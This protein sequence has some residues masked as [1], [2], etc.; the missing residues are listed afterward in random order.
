MQMTLL[1]T[2]LVFVLRLLSLSS[3]AFS[4]GFVKSWFCSLYLTIIC[5][6]QIRQV[7]SLT[8][9]M[10]IIIWILKHQWMMP[11]EH[12]M[13][14]LLNWGLSRF[15]AIWG[16]QGQVAHLNW[17]E[18]WKLMYILTRTVCRGC[19]SSKYSCIYSPGQYAGAASQV[20]TLF[21]TYSLVN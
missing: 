14:H 9:R 15:G 5:S 2:F 7:S 10:T 4:V 20:C 13:T 6:L 21:E 1:S 17:T 12:F 19:Q 11:T 18:C 16:H 3:G 8:G